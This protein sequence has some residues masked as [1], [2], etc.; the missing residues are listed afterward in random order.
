M[1]PWEHWGEEGTSQQDPWLARWRQAGVEAAAMRHRAE[2]EVASRK[3]VP[4][5]ILLPQVQKSS[6]RAPSGQKR[7]AVR[8]R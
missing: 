7:R 8:G 3:R 2:Q 1:K 4:T 6:T 5:P